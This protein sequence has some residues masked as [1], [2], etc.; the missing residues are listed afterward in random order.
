V[1]VRNGVHHFEV[2]IFFLFLKR[3]KIGI[4]ENVKRLFA[5]LSGVGARLLRNVRR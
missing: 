5:A 3:S 2:L 1:S 4:S